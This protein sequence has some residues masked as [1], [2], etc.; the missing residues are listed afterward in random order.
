MLEKKL[1]CCH[2][3][4]VLSQAYVSEEDLRHYNCQVPCPEYRPHHVNGEVPISHGKIK[5]VLGIGVKN[6][7]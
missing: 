3:I 4:R 2:K 6:E 5:Y 7:I 1:P